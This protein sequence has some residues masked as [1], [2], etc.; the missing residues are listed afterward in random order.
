MLMIT[1]AMF[2]VN[3]V[4]YTLIIMGWFDIGT[5]LIAEFISTFNLGFAGSYILGII[6]KG[7]AEN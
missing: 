2:A 3:I 7:K 4:L 6:L 5:K 1:L